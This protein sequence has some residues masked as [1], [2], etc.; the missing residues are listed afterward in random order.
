MPTRAESIDEEP[1]R[2][3]ARPQPRESVGRFARRVES[4]LRELRRKERLRAA[5]RK[6]PK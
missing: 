6:R 2:G 3:P 5:A 1:G 4:Q